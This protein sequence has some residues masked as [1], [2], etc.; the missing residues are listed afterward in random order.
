MNKNQEMTSK[1]RE[2]FIEANFMDKKGRDGSLRNPF[3]CYIN[4]GSPGPNLPLLTAS[5]LEQL[6]QNR[7]Y[8][9]IWASRWDKSIVSVAPKFESGCV[10]LSDGDVLAKNFLIV[11]TTKLIDQAT[12]L[13]QMPPAG[14]YTIGI[15]DQ[16]TTIDAFLISYFHM[17][18]ELIWDLTVK[19]SDNQKLT[20]ASYSDAIDYVTRVGF[21]I[22][23][24]PEAEIIATKNNTDVSVRIYG[25]QVNPYVP[26][27]LGLVKKNK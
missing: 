20:V 15:N 7:D 14:E 8:A 24:M 23:L 6:Q 22:M 19:K 10:F 9:F 16:P 26:K 25:S 1:D 2:S 11:S 12:L 13:S 3:T 21:S 4:I 18:N 17:L 5:F 27:I